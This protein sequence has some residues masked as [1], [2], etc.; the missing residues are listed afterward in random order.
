MGLVMNSELLI[1]L[2]GELSRLKYSDKSMNSLQLK[3]NINVEGQYLVLY[4]YGFF[5]G[6][7]VEIHSKFRKVDVESVKSTFSMIY[8]MLK[9]INPSKE[10]NNSLHSGNLSVNHK[11]II[12]IIVGINKTIEYMVKL[13][14]DSVGKCKYDFNKNMFEYYLENIKTVRDALLLITILQEPITIISKKDKLIIRQ[15]LM[16]VVYYSVKNRLNE[17]INVSIDKVFGNV[18]VKMHSSSSHMTKVTQFNIN[19]VLK[20]NFEDTV[21]VIYSIFNKQ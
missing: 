17:K 12:D 4:S 5:R 11:I 3:H 20:K 9:L 8:D 16:G 19:I 21:K 10:F 15:V 6:I 1:K 2:A 14:N 7:P 13:P 18:S